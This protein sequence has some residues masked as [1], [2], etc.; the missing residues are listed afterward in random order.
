MGTNFYMMTKFKK[1]RDKYFNWNYELTDTPDWGYRQHIAKTSSGWCPL[2][3]ASGCFKSI[4]ELKNIYDSGDFILHD[5]YGQIYTWDEFDE[6]V[7]KFNGGISGADPKYKLSE[8]Q[9]SFYDENMPEY[10]PVSHCSGSD[11]TYKFD[12]ECAKEYYKDD[13]RYEFCLRTFF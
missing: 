5:E 3:D 13:E 9:G 7:L 1:A 8:K 6:R 4:R 2:F 12:P 11:C 10:G